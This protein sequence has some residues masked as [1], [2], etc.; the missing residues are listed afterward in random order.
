MYKLKHILLDIIKIGFLKKAG[1][2]TDVAVMPRLPAITGNFFIALW[3]GKRKAK[4]TCVIV[5]PDTSLC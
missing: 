1:F 2:K 4:A 3:K 5:E